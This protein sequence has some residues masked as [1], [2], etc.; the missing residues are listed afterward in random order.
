VLVCFRCDVL[1][2]HLGTG[3]WQW[4]GEDL[5][6]FTAARPQLLA[7]CKEALPDDREIATLPDTLN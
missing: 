5:R 4:H 1:C 3:A 2:A 7:L 6:D